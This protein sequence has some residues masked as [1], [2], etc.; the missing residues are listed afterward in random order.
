[1]S[2][3]L[4]TLFWFWANQSLLFLLNAGFIYSTSSFLSK[5]RAK[6]VE[7]LHNSS[8]YRKF[9]KWN[10]GI[11]FWNW[12]RLFPVLPIIKKKNESRPTDPRFFWHATVNTHIII[13]GVDSLHSRHFIVSWFFLSDLSL[14]V[15]HYYNH[16]T[17]ET[18]VV[19]LNIVWWDLK[20]IK[21]CIV[22][23]ASL[24]SGNFSSSRVILCYSIIIFFFNCDPIYSGSFS[25]WV[26]I[27]M[28][29]YQW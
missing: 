16:S 3:H 10:T 11:G 8:F 1:M 5:L 14:I 23:C 13:V 29:N 21:Q 18:A 4:N 26:I 9:R 2:A 24:T 15:L 20:V 7:K 17:T 19:V 22:L 12:E 6:K 27:V 25:G 28:E